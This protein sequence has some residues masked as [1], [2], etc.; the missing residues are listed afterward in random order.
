MAQDWEDLKKWVGEKE[1]CIDYLAIPAVQ[2][3]SATLDRGDGWRTQVNSI[4]TEDSFQY[5]LEGYTK[6]AK[7]QRECMRRTIQRR[8][9]SFIL[10]PSASILILFLSASICGSIGY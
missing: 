10:H 8:F 3:L 6:D 7:E 9:P 2:R 1:T 4:N 5:P